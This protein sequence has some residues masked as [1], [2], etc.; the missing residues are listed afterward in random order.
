ML[1]KTTRQRQVPWQGT[2][3]HGYEIHHGQ[4]QAGESVQTYLLD[5]LGWCQDNVYGVYVH[6]LF[7]NAPYRQQFLEH[8]GWR[9]H[10]TDEWSAIVDASLEQVA[11]LIVE[12]GWIV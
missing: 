7:D 4:T 9:G 10:T 8:L 1:D 5:G 6:G 3:L 2:L 12:S 11:Q